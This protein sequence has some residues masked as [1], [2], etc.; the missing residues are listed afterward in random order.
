MS[1]LSHV[2]H[3]LRGYEPNT[4]IS[5]SH[6]KGVQPL[7]S[8]LDPKSILVHPHPTPTQ[9]PWV[10]LRLIHQPVYPETIREGIGINFK[11]H[12]SF[13]F[14]FRLCK[15][16]FLLMSF[17]LGTR[18]LSTRTP[19]HRLS[20]GVTTPTELHFIISGTEKLREDDFL[21]SRKI[22]EYFRISRLPS[23]KSDIMT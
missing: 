9:T 20:F 21:S 3:L 6:K 8:P 23:K 18:R 12:R 15:S 13:P 4:L 5:T 22:L 16:H 1:P 14:L 17:W 10:S 7:W 11:H 2:P 19:R